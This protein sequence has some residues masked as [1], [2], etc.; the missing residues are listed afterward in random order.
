MDNIIASSLPMSLQ[1]TRRRIRPGHEEPFFWSSWEKENAENIVS[2]M[3]PNTAPSEEESNNKI[4]AVLESQLEGLY[5]K[6]RSRE[7]KF[8]EAISKKTLKIANPTSIA[9]ASNNAYVKDFNKEVSQIIYKKGDALRKLFQDPDYAAF[10]S[11]TPNYFSLTKASEYATQQGNAKSKNDVSYDLTNL[12]LTTAGKN[13]VGRVSGRQNLEIRNMLNNGKVDSAWLNQLATFFDTYVGGGIAN[14]I[15]ND[16]GYRKAV[17][18]AVGN[19]LQEI[20]LDD[21]R[22]NIQFGKGS[23]RLASF[24]SK[25]VGKGISKETEATLKA[26]FKKISAQIIDI[27]NTNMSFDT[28]YGGLKLSKDAKVGDGFYE[29]HITSKLYSTGLLTNEQMLSL[30]FEALR[31]SIQTYCSSNSNYNVGSLLRTFDRNKSKIREI[32]TKDL[33]K[34]KEIVRTSEG[35]RKILA[36][37]GYAQTRGILGELAVALSVSNNI[38]ESSTSI[39]GSNDTEAGEVSMD[40]VAVIQNNKFG[41]QV[42]NFKG[43]EHRGFYATD[44][45]VKN[46]KIMQKYFGDYAEGYYWLFANEEALNEAGLIDDFQNR[47][48]YSFYDFSDNFLR[49]SAGDNPD[50]SYSDAFFIGDKIIP[51]SYMYYLLVR[52]VKNA[53]QN[54]KRFL[55]QPETN[56]NKNPELERGEN[57]KPSLIPNLVN[58]MNARIE[59]KGINFNLE[60]IFKEVN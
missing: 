23:S 3:L 7:I 38:S 31:N 10:L 30:L 40:V 12:F 26:A 57:F 37:W 1:F 11:R 54:K 36:K 48:E 24:G 56:Q 46:E 43:A 50:F 16:P 29:V 27:K 25:D 47:L 19:S 14:K 53:K 58:G 33:V 22:F 15:Q 49:I 8:L 45:S 55:L 42:K 13:A 59:F 18:V 52:T 35:V 39:S 60:T 41:F 2:L 17:E 4:V 51:S 28:E 5:E 9:D 20:L 32:I 6:A 21:S 44:F 34:E